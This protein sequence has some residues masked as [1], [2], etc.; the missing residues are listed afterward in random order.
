MEA[1]LI[2]WAA[3]CSIQSPLQLKKCCFCFVISKWNFLYFKFCP[4]LLI[5]SQGTTEK[6]LTLSSSIIFFSL[7]FCT[8]CLSLLVSKLSNPGALKLLYN[9]CSNLLINFMTLNRTYSSMSRSP[10][11]ADTELDTARQVWPQQC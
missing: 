4:L 1:P 10:V 8:H 3:C 6:S 9:R 11:L 5:L 2:L 7:G